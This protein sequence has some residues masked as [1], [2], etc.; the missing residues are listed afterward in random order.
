MHLYGNNTAWGNSNLQLKFLATF[1][2]SLPDMGVPVLL[3][4]DD[5][6]GHWTQLVCYYTTA[7]SFIMFKV[8]PDYSSVYQLAHMYWMNP[9][10]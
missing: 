2:T 4:L 9:L 7:I 10:Y 3:F 5:F 8:S 1:F 6:I